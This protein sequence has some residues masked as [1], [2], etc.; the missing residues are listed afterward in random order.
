MT[1]SVPPLH[2]EHKFYWFQLIGNNPVVSYYLNLI[3][4]KNFS[5]KT[6][7][8][9]RLE[10]NWPYKG[11]NAHK[12]WKRLLLQTNHSTEYEEHQNLC[13]LST[14]V[15]NMPKY[16]HNNML[17]KILSKYRYRQNSRKYRNIYFLS[18]LHTPIILNMI[19]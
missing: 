4:F 11:K 7:H 1:D 14:A 18:L 3:N 9:F 12:S 15:L 13:Q 5:Q 8:T 10:K 19:E 6:M 17:W 2:C 16:Q